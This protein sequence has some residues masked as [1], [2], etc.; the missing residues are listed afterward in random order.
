MGPF[1]APLFL[2]ILTKKR[3]Y[4]KQNDNN[5]AN[6]IFYVTKYFFLACKDS[7]P[8]SC[9]SGTNGTIFR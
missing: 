1:I 3:V 9:F 6:V 8:N 5:M 4:Q 7:C 2:K